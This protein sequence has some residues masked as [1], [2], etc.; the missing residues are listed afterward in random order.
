MRAPRALGCRS[1]LRERAPPAPRCYPLSHPLGNLRN[2]ALLRLTELYRLCW[3]QRG[4]F[5][6][7]RPGDASVGTSREPVCRCG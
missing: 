2:V 3:S 1:L 4:V 7:R 6:P 5:A